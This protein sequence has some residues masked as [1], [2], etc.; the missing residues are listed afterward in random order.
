MTEGRNFQ[1]MLYLLAGD[2]ILE[3]ERQTDPNAPTN[4]AGGTFWHLN[5]NISGAINMDKPE[6]EAALEEAQA[7]PVSIYSRAPEICK[8]AKPQSKGHMFTLL[9]SPN[10]C[11]V[12]I[13]NRRA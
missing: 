11:R 7:R 2:A 8:C 13:I 5:R 1:M 3:R 12:S 4:I 10:Y 6:D 9:H